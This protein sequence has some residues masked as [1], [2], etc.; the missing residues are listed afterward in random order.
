VR[1]EEQPAAIAIDRNI[2]AVWS[3]H[4][5]FHHVAHEHDFAVKVA[6]GQTVLA[7]LLNA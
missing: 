2:R 6:R 4:P 3:R 1:I 7:A 5:R